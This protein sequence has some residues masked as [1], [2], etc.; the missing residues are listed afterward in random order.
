MTLTHFCLDNTIRF[1]TVTVNALLI[2]ICE[3]VIRQLRERNC[4]VD[5][6]AMTREMA[7]L[8]EKID[9]VQES[10]DSTIGLA[11]SERNWSH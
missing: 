6:K 5:G 1:V 4:G 3:E 7:L 2:H 10:Q 8:G 11:P 9:G